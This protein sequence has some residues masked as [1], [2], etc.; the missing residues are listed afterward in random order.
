VKATDLLRQQHREVETLFERLRNAEGIERRELARELAARLAAHMRIEEEI[1]Y[2]MA[3][4]IDPD[5]IEESLEEHTVA[6]FALKR[7]A[8]GGIDHPSAR[9]KIEVLRELVMHHVEEEERSLLPKLER[10]LGERNADLGSELE[11]RFTTIVDSGYGADL[12]GRRNGHAQRGGR[13][14]R[15]TRGSARTA[16]R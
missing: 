13:G 8:E 9:A 10:A 7:L 6:A 4:D 11:E 15:M 12:F 2:P 14:G 3:R 1:V 5:T 16:H